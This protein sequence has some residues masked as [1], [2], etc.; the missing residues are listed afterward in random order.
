LKVNDNVAVRLGGS[1]SEEEP[2]FIK[3]SFDVLVKA[4]F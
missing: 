4:N 3:R 1:Y 2:S